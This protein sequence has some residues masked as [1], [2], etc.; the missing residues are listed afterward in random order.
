VRLPDPPLLVVTDRA[1]ARY[2]LLDVVAASCAAGCRWI[3]LREKNLPAAKQIELAHTLRQVTRKYAARLTLHGSPALARAAGVDGVH[4]AAG[5]DVMAARKLLGADALIGLSV[6]A[7][8]EVADRNSG[9]VDYVIAGPVHPTASKP[10]YGPALGVEELGRIVRATRVPVIAIG[11]V[12]PDNI[13]ALVMAGAAGIAV[14]G[15][16]MRA[17]T[18]GEEVSALA[19]ALTTARGSAAAIGGDP[20]IGHP[21]A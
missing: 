9:I 8:D 4:L 10:G 20:L 2:P 15:G 16:V 1:Q 18:P 13:T 17:D 19:A 11:G 12:T 21:K 7:A 3:S 5:G 6:H 14:M